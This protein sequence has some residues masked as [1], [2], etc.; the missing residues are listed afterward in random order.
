[1]AGLAT[2]AAASAAAFAPRRRAHGLYWD[3]GRSW[4]LNH[5]PTLVPKLKSL[6]IDHVVVN[7][8]GSE[9]AKNNRAD[10]RWT[11]EQ[12]R[13]LRVPGGPDIHAMVWASP[14]RAFAIDFD[15]YCQSLRKA[16]IRVVEL[17]VER[18]AWGLAPA[19][20]RSHADAAAEL[21]RIARKHGLTIGVT[22]IPS[23]MYAEFHGADYVSVQAYSK[24]NSGQ[25]NH[26]PTGYYGPGQM[27]E[28]A[29][30]AALSAR[31]PMVTALAA[32]DQKWPALDGLAGMTIAYQA[33]VQ[34]SRCVRWWSS[35]W[36]VG[37]R[38]QADVQ[39]HIRAMIRNDA[40]MV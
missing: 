15:R 17:D 38:A 14:T 3:D 39:A 12:L 23:R 30:R 19:G 18:D 11:A 32:Y 13:Q 7:V 37:S 10:G 8:N 6:G 1:M 31:M 27:Q 29:Y 4:T 34:R 22:M 20:Y 36:V 35:K 26:G 16:G 9:A 33:A 24:Y 25:E 2:A 28:R 40:P 21:L 5:W